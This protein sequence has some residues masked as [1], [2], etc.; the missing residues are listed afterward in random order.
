MKKRELVLVAHIIS[1]LPEPCRSF[2]ANAFALELRQ[3]NAE[4]RLDRFLAACKAKS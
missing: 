3:T 1:T 4:F 2:A